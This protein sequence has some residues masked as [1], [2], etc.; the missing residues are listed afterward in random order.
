V[1]A[2]YAWN[3]DA[4]FA[5][6]GMWSYG[7]RIAVCLVLLFP[8]AFLMGFPFALGMGTLA[9][10]NKERFFVWAWGINGSFS[11]VGSVLVPVVSV[12]FGLSAAL[13]GAAALY[14]LAI[15]AFLQLRLPDRSVQES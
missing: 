2:L 13:L 12:L 15:P 11:V 1:L 9:R 6:I 5:A 8:L 14:L 10:L 4:L 3:L 7:A